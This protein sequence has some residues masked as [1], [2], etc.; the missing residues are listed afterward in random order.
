MRALVVCGLA[1]ALAG[2][3][4]ALPPVRC[5][6]MADVRQCEAAK[7]LEWSAGDRTTL[8]ATMNRLRGNELVRGLLAGVSA[9]GYRG[10]N[11]YTTETQRTEAGA[12]VAKFG[13]GFVLYGPK[14][15]GITDAFFEL[16]EVR[17]ARSGYR[18]GDLVLLHELVH[19]YD[20]RQR[21]SERA[22]TALTGWT[23]A[24]GR[25]QYTNRVNLSEYHGVYAETLTLYARGR[26]AEAWTRDRTFATRLAVPVPRLQSLVSPAEAYADIVAHL[27]LD[28]TARDYLAKPVVAWVEQQVF[29]DLRALASGLR[30]VS[31]A[32]DE[33]TA[34]D[35]A[36]DQHTRV[37]AAQVQRAAG[38]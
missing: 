25:W 24:D 34:A 2:D 27:I 35:A 21:S 1:A 30:D 31:S 38:R 12:H 16:A 17:D 11:R 37:D 23:L 18:A 20:D 4:V 22:F 13:P 6:A 7:P 14:V 5:E 29:R 9:N 3:L 8:D 15:I 36:G 28:P 10:F 33:V 19:A 32:R 26:H